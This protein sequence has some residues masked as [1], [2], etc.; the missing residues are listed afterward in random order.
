M[1]QVGELGWLPSMTR[2]PAVTRLA[3]P[4]TTNDMASV[5]IRAL[6]RNA[7]TI[8]PLTSPSP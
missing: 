7:V 2:F 3:R 5:A 8:T 6:I 4:L 1:G